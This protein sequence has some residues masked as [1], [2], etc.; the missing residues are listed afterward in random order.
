MTIAEI[1][2]FIYVVKSNLKLF[3][4]FF[5]LKGIT[6]RFYIFTMHIAP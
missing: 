6:L 4:L 2:K 5:N 3:E 1:S